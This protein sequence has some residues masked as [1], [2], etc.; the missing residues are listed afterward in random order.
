MGFLLLSG[1]N[2]WGQIGFAIV[3]IET[4]T[5]GGVWIPHPTLW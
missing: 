1:A 4:A 3:L 5:M 2:Q